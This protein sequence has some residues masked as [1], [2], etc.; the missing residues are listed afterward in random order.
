VN[1]TGVHDQLSMT[2]TVVPPGRWET[3]GFDAERGS[4]GAVRN[5]KVKKET[6]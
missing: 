3:Q 6:S 1:D 2:S 5:L 4:I